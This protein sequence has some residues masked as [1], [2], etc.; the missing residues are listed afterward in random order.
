MRRYDQP[1]SR[2]VLESSDSTD[3]IDQTGRHLPPP[4]LSPL[5]PPPSTHL[6]THDNN[7]VNFGTPP[8]SS[9]KK[10]HPR[11]KRRSTER[12]SPDKE[13]QPL[14]TPTHH[15]PLDSKTNL[16]LVPKTLG[17]QFSPRDQITTEK[18]VPTRL[19]LKG[20][21]H[22]DGARRSIEGGSKSDDSL[23]PPI[24]PGGTLSPAVDELLRS[25]QQKAS[26]SSSSTRDRTHRRTGSGGSA[27]L[28]PQGWRNSSATGTPGSGRHST[29]LEMAGVRRTS[30]PSL[31][32]SHWTRSNKQ[33]QQHQQQQTTP[34]LREHR[35]KMM[36]SVPY[37]KLDSSDS[38]SDT[39]TYREQDNSSYSGTSSVLNRDLL[40]TH[41]E[42][43]LLSST[44]ARGGQS[45]TTPTNHHQ[46]PTIHLLP[47]PN[48]TLQPPPVY[49][50]ALSN[51]SSC[52]ITGTDGHD[53]DSESD[54]GETESATEDHYPTTTT[55]NTETIS[56]S[57]S[58][59][60]T[61][62]FCSSATPHPPSTSSDHYNTSPLSS[63][64]LGSPV[65][66]NFPSSVPLN[67]PSSSSPA[68]TPRP[69]SPPPLALT[70]DREPDFTIITATEEEGEIDT[71]SLRDER[72]GT[73][74][75]EDVCESSIT[76]QGQVA[77]LIS[78]FEV[79]L[80]NSMTASGDHT[81]DPVC[82][83][84]SSGEVEPESPRLEIPLHIR[85]K[86]HHQNLTRGSYSPVKVEQALSLLQD[87]GLGNSTTIVRHFFENI[88]SKGPPEE[89]GM[90][91]TYNT[92]TELEDSGFQVTTYTVE[93]SEQGTLWG[94][95][96]L[97]LV[98]SEVV[99]ISE[100]QYSNTLEY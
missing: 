53:A 32:P 87:S 5:T 93:T 78:Q 20:T 49:S 95:L 19:N 55:T 14:A 48:A 80:N 7:T 94:Q 3:D 65:P 42:S 9:R 36:S 17:A 31:S 8:T 47:A 86:Q 91:R 29:V 96:I 84:V 72:T 76:S 26:P 59:S 34:L 63:S 58:L 33:H 13:I 41:Q 22:T 82:E 90:N 6:L 54:C 69:L 40:K 2:T 62:T 18:M 24:T 56:H 11:R 68:G 85:R 60:P 99:P 27:N 30:S 45:T 39:E 97:S 66:P 38:D 73:T 46:L 15:Q 1:A 37:S 92:T 50:P 28:L 88:V 43:Q 21:N 35:E 25:V 51:E 67:F 77:M 16:P 12:T 61:P 23:E 74:S 89:V 83:P 57:F 75:E 79:G 81:E 98:Y 71:H 64:S 10:P 44:H 4:P 70:D 100:V 52:D